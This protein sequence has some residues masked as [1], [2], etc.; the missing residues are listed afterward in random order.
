MTEQSMPNPV[1]LYGEVVKN[2]KQIITNVRPDQTGASTP[3]SEWDGRR[4]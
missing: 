2:T 1:E 4:S 3:C